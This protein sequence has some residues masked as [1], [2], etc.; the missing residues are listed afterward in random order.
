MGLWG[1]MSEEEPPNNVWR[2]PCVDGKLVVVAKSH[3]KTH[4]LPTAA[5][6]VRG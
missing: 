3:Q 2:L 5:E 1:G 4:D 6:A